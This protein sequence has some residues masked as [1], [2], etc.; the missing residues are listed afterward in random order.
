MKKTLVLALLA[1]AV[2][3][4]VPVGAD[5][6][7]TPTGVNVNSQGATT[8][9]IS[10]GQLANQVSVEA[11]WCGALIPAAPDRGFKC[12]PSTVWGRLP[13]RY[14]QSTASG[15]RGFTDIMTIP[16]NLARRAYEAAARGGSQF[17]YV[18][19][20]QST[21]GG[22]DEYVFVT[23]RLTGGGALTPL[24][25]LDVRIEFVSE[26]P[27]LSVR[28]GTAPPPIVAALS[29]T[30]S[31]RLKGRWEVVKP[32]DQLPGVDDLLPEATLPI[33]QRP[34][35]RRYQELERFNVFL[36][37]T[38]TYRLPGPDPR[39]L[40][41][42][43]EGLY[44]VVLRIEAS[45]DTDGNADLGSVGEGA[46]VVRTGGVAGFPLPPLRY[47][48]GTAE[49]PRLGVRAGFLTQLQPS[50]AAIVTSAAELSWIEMA[51]AAFY[52]LEVMDS[53]GSVV[54]AA[55]L[56]PGTGAYRLPPWVADKAQP[57]ALQWRVLALD[58]D[59]EQ[60]AT[61]DWR[62][63][64]FATPAATNEGGGATP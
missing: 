54:I 7:R 2:L 37:P 30:G 22:P 25:L 47:Y 49:S 29:Y 20:F 40:P 17:F 36:P 60:L 15:T 5:I 57:G 31:G 12:D 10:Y 48:V 34:L 44:Q 43:A 26:A 1:L 8:V 58:P 16:Q 63:F 32:G 45:D 19:R 53:G 62:T 18:R 14:D 55:L 6:L 41:T 39:R 27:V 51:G 42:A 38:G 13:L 9:F 56:Q 24:A 11:L 46:G 21:V 28:P 61:T 50:E 64:T 33:E 4:G 52:R 3:A 35:Q 59:G 23:C